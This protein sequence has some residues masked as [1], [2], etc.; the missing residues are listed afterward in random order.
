MR[1]LFITL[2]FSPLLVCKNT[3]TCQQKKSTTAHFS[4]P[5]L[6]SNNVKN[7]EW[8]EKVSLHYKNKI[9]SNQEI[10]EDINQ[11]LYALNTFYG[12]K[13]FLPKEVIKKAKSTL[14]K[15]N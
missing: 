6:A 5:G 9:L 13:D 14:K 4:S 11:L 10:K 1:F 2:F 8:P 15:K 7:F 12:G 3:C